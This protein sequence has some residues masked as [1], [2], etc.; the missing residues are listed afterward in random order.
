MNQQERFNDQPIRPSD[1]PAGNPAGGNLDAL[2]QQAAGL[3]A[4]AEAAIRNALSSDSKAFNAAMRQEG[5]Q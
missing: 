3:H 4:A 2:R 1:D 5:G